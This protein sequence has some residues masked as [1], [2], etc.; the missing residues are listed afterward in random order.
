MLDKFWIYDI[1]MST[2]FC[3]AFI[4]MLNLFGFDCLWIAVVLI[5]YIV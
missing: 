2:F 4:I 5:I 3:S 1:K